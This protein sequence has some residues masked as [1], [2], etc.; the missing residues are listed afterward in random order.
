MSRIFAIMDNDNI[1]F[2]NGSLE[3]IDNIEETDDVYLILPDDYFYFFQTDIISKRKTLQTV[4][5]YAKTLFTNIDFVGYVKQFTPVVGYLFNKEKV[6]QLDK[7]VVDRVVFVTTPFLVYAQEK[8]DF[9]Y[10]GRNVSALVVDGK[11]KFYAFGDESTLIERLTKEV[12]IV[13]FDKK[14]VLEKLSEALKVGSFK[15]IALDI[16]NKSGI[17]FENWKIYRFVAVLV[18]CLAFVVGEGLR[19]ASYSKEVKNTQ[20]RLEELYRKALG[21][22]QQYA[23]PYGVL[24]YKA[25]YSSQTD[26]FSLSKVLYYLSEAKDG[27][28]L[29]VDYISYSN[30]TLKI[31]GSID[32][33]KNL[34][35]F[36]DKLNNI[37][38]RKL[39]V[40]NTS[41]KGG[42]LTFVLVGGMN[43]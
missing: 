22:D 28:S 31:K 1:E 27:Y 9:G 15:R 30:G 37:M 32:N 35:S 16:G 19:Y 42:K 4:R 25:N 7:G 23:D 21:N 36:L 13:K 34:L 12:K 41:S 5:A 24:L 39:V 17:G 20:K 2:Y 6:E 3:K 33:Y 10:V 38:G 43:G 29:K 8:G 11:L 40:Q 14:G 26:P 18:V